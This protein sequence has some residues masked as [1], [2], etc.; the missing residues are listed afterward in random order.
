MCD[1]TSVIYVLIWK[2]TV[3]VKAEGGLINIEYTYNNNS[4]EG[5]IVLGML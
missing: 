3:N 5:F 4:F 1:I 2:C